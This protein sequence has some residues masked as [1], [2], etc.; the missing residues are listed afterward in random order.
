M[1][2][3]TFAD[4]LKAWRKSQKIIQKEA[5]EIL[6]VSV[7]TYQGWECG[8]F[9]PARICEGCVRKKMDEVAKGTVQ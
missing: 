6:G 2:D 1:A 7:R 3:A 8:T 5:A 9:H 4:E